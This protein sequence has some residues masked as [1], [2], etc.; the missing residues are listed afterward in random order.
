MLIDE[1]LEFFF[2]KI[3]LFL[4]FLRKRC[5]EEADYKVVFAADYEEAEACKYESIFERAVTK[6]E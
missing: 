4:I 1:R 3:K 2:A 6:I 5:Y